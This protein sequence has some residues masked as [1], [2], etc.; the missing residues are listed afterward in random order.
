MKKI[1]VCF[2]FFTLVLTASSLEE[3]IA[4]FDKELAIEMYERSLSSSQDSLKIYVQL[5]QLYQETGKIGLARD[6]YSQLL[7]FNHVSESTYQHY[8]TFL[9]SLG[10]YS[11]VRRSIRSKYNEKEWG[12]EFIAKSYFFE[13]KFDS[14]IQFAQALQ[15]PLSQKMINLSHEGL[16]LHNRSPF[17]AGAMSA[18]I[19]GSG[20]MYAGRFWDGLQAFSMVV[21]PAY[22]AYDHFK[23]KG[24]KT[25][26]GWL[27]TSVATWFYLSDI[28]G[29]VKA[30]YE[31]N[32]MQRFKIIEKL[33]K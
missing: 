20:K 16:A 14:S 11:E 9:F 17:L 18:I 24:I 32:E 13:A 21:A 10:E 26:E 1:I 22:N 27:W 31:Y 25:F 28:Y 33:E 30:C 3:Y 15:T 19:P 2:L 5:A 8:L 12:Q 7:S 6:A 29:S 23:T 4:N